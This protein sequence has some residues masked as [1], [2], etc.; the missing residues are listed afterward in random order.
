M[1]RSGW[2]GTISFGLVGVPVA[3]FTAT[4]EHQPSFHQFA[5][6]GTD[7]IRYKRVNERTGDE[8]DF[9]DLVQG[10]EVGDG[11]FVM[12]TDDELEQI[13]P[14]RSRSL[15]I[16]A[17]VDLDTI[18]PIYFNKAYY[19]GPAAQENTKTYALLR[20]A[21]AASNRAGIATFLM[22]GKEYLAAI[23][24]SGDT[25][26][27]ETLFFADEVRD[28]KKVLGDLS[29]ASAFGKGELD[30]ANQLIKSM[31]D[32]WDPGRYKD[33]HT[34]RVKTLIEAKRKG[35][36]VEDAEDAP[37]STNVVDL[38]EALRRSVESARA[39]AK[40]PSPARKAAKKS[41]AKT[42]AKKAPARKAPARNAEARKAAPAKETT[43]ARKSTRRA[44]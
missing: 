42:P 7:R 25:M 41:S 29:G 24:A 39:G 36:Q 20:E 15:E 16:S 35:E 31:D 30:R 23:R 32:Q 13:A 10:V 26:V 22:H 44:S 4:D 12:V 40:K 21:M 28:P 5:A 17:F 19:I 8:V 43:S 9:A 6:G 3:L 38:L 11:Q 2:S 34:D 33:V 27:L 18:D 37:A 14:G 1:A